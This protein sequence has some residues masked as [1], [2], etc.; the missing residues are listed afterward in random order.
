MQIRVNGT[1]M[2]YELM[3]RKDQPVLIMSH[4]LGSSLRMWDSQIKVLEPHFRILRYDLRGHGGS[5][6][7]P[8][9]YTLELLGEDALKLL[10]ELGIQAVHWLGISIGG[11]IGQNVALNHGH[12]LRSLV[13][14]DTTSRM[15]EESQ[16]IWQERINTVRRKGVQALLESTMERWFTPSFLEKNPSELALMK[17]EFLSTTLEGYIGCSEAIRKLDY[18][19]RLREINLPTL[20]MVGE[21]DLGAPVAA[22]RAMHEQIANSKLIVIPSACHIPNVEHPAVFNAALIGFFKAI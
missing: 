11:M 21:N 8:G 5:E 7:K 15:P 6:A 17:K 18:F 19:D 10:D 4:S 22:S 20:I 13:L 9:P 1:G 16:P 14:C 2:N 3:G 12:R